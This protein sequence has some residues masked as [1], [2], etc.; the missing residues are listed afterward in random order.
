MLENHLYFIT[1]KFDKNFFKLLR[2]VLEAGVRLIQ[3]REKTL[4]D[5]L[6]YYIGKHIRKICNEYDAIYIVND[7]VD[8]AISTDADGVH[9]GDDD[10]PITAA[11]E[12]LGKD[13]IIGKTVRSVD[14]AIVAEKL[15]ADYLGAGSVF[16]SKTKPVD[17]I[18]G[19]D[20][21][22]EIVNSV[23]IPVYAIGGIDEDNI[24][25][26]LKTNVH[27]VA[28]VSAISSSKNPK[29]KAKKLLEKIYSYKK[30]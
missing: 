25:H 30:L 5:K 11:R 24:D 14:D 6:K 23:K 2:D 26:V 19:I 13:Y 15:G 18:I 20:I 17:K 9:L 10:L 29:E 12:I 3:F 1:P 27:G 16:K 8:I 4:S 22:R 21:L 28:L 7:R